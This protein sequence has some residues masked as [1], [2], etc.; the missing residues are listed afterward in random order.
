MPD[1]LTLDE[2]IA[3]ILERAQPLSSE[4]VPLDQA[5]GRVVAEPASASVDL[6]PFASSAMDGFAVRSEDTPG[7]LPVAARIAAGSPS[8]T[9]L[10]PGTAAA[11]AT[12]AAVPE[13]ADAIVPVEQS[14]EEN[15]RVALAEAARPGAHIRPRGGDV[16]EGAPVVVAGT[17]LGPAQI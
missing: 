10:E 3:R 15:G 5:A 11:I 17:R 9:A 16:Q 14:A 7:T 1:L 6:P 12:G 13:G 2:A 8:P 4:V